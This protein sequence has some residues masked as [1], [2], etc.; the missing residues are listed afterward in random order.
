[1]SKPFTGNATGYEQRVGDHRAI[2][3]WS[4]FQGWASEMVRQWDGQYVLK[5]FCDE[6]NPQDFLKGVPDNQNVPWTNPEP[7][8]TFLS[9]PVLASDL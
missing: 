7:P 9:A 6:R 1:M 8:D 4:G 5:R 3:A 2:C